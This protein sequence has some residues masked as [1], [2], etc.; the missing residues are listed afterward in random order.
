M[1]KEYY[2]IARFGKR[3]KARIK[4]YRFKTRRGAML[5]GRIF[6]WYNPRC[7]TYTVYRD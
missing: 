2:I 1:S 6:L 3:R 5:F 7:R 4:E